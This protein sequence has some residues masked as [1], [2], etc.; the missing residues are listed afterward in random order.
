MC[1]KLHKNDFVILIFFRHLVACLQGELASVMPNF[2]SD[3][4]D[5]SHDPED[6][7]TASVSIECTTITIN[8]LHCWQFLYF[9]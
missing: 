1:F 3:R 7:S 5:L 6:S 9:Q 4:D 2:L 8:S